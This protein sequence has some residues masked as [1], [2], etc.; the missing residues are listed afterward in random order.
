MTPAQDTTRL[1]GGAADLYDRYRPGYPDALYE[2]ILERAKGRGL[3]VDLGAGTGKAL[4][5]L[6]GTFAKILAVEP[7]PNMAALIPP[8][9]TL[10]VAK[11]TA[12]AVPLPARGV[13]LFTC[14]T[15]FHWFDGPRV[16]SRLAEAAAPGAL[17][18]VFTY[19]RPDPGPAAKRVIETELHER[20]DRHKN[21]RLGRHDYADRAIA[22]HPAWTGPE[23]TKLPYRFEMS[24]DDLAGFYA[25]TSYASEYLRTLD[26]PQRYL[27][28]LSAKLADAAGSKTLRVSLP[29]E[30]R[31]ST[32]AEDTP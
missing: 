29:V 8:A 25:S 21:D 3:A 22:A 18:A 6:L 1:F 30:T 4:P 7:D 26:D 14:G 23:R 13:D 32:L 24:T 12:E 9:P 5:P 27:D 15:A 31:L 11:T 28:D 20:W 19:Y 16:L 17:L 2:L 10:T